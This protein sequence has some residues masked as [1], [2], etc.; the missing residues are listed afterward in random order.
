MVK[1]CIQLGL[2]PDINNAVNM[3][4]VDS[5]AR[6][7]TLS[8]ITP[9]FSPSLVTVFHITA[10][11]SIRFNDI[12]SSLATFGYTVQQT[13]YLEWR[14]RLEQHVIEIQDNA[15]FP[16]LHF[17][18]DDLPTSTKGPELNDSNTSALIRERN[19]EEYGRAVDV[20][21]M[22]MYLAWLVEAGFLDPPTTS[23]STDGNV[24]AL[25]KLEGGSG[26]KAIGRTGR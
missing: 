18:L 19:S 12:L 6:Y 10:R 15:L 1:G 2:V 5:V 24:R 11:P 25:P 7:V 16:L 9:P 22:G 3:V 20:D 17:V 14:R 26:A 21:L 13:G 4:P 8:G 23:P